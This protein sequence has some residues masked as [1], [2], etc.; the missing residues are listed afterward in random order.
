MG[1][2]KNVY[3]YVDGGQV[4]VWWCLREEICGE[5]EEFLSAVSG[6]ETFFASGWGLC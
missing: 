6:S 3:V 4:F 1:G 2:V 5:F